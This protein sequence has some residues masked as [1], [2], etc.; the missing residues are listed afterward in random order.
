MDKLRQI[1]CLV[2]GLAFAVS[3]ARAE[4]VDVELFL[5]VDVSGS[6]NAEELQIQRD[7][8]VA[9]FRSSDVINAILT[10]AR[11]RVA[12]TYV[13]WAH[14]DLQRVIAPWQLIASAAD[15]EDFAA[16]LEAAPL[17][18]MRNTSISGILVQAADAFDTNG[19]EGDR[20]VI[21][22]SGDG[23]NNQGIP[24]IQARDR[25]VARGI[26]INGL[27]ILAEPWRTDTH[28]ILPTLD[29][30][31]T[32]CVIGGPLSFLLPVRNW[33]EFPAAVRQ[34]LVLELSGVSPRSNSSRVIPAQ[35]SGSFLET[36]PRVDCMIGEKLRRARDW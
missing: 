16:R 13:E 31:Y 27:P 2:F 11:G 8:Y 30:Y 23:P 29:D 32:A 36:K 3:V 25:A 34:K 6:M 26:T 22:V 28:F 35:F 33:D 7:G 12:V 20:L 9:A 17:G 24:V 5:A 4:A 15:A 19:F 18:N 14:T 21:D 10:G 1:V